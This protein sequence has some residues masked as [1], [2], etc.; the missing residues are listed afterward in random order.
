MKDHLHAASNR[1]QTTAAE[2]SDVDSIEDH[3]AGRR[4][5]QTNDRFAKRGLTAPTFADHSESFALADFET[6]IVDGVNFCDDLVEDSA[7]LRK[8]LD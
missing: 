2:M 4:I 5:M 8:M 1:S 3:S 7:T 6:N